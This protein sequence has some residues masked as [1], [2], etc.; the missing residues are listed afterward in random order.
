MAHEPDERRS[1]AATLTLFCGLP[2]SGKTTLA[3]RLEREGKGVRICTDEWQAELGVTFTDED[4]HERLQAL[5]YRHALDLLRA[6]CDVILED[7]LW[8]AEER[9]EKFRDARRC[10]ARIEFHVFDLP[11]EEL[12]LRLESRTP[13]APRER[14]R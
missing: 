9:T 3:R 8:R 2:G 14:R 13:S 5:L 10:D 11:Q 12:W 4:F 1:D 7:G 6:G